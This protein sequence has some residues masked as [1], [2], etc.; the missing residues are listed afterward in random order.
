GALYN[1]RL[2]TRWV[3]RKMGCILAHVPE[4][5]R[6]SRRNGPSTA[7][8]SD[9]GAQVEVRAGLEPGDRIILNPPIGVRDGMRVQGVQDDST[10][11]ASAPPH[12]H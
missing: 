11:M 1:R 7:G 9:D 2:F 3:N 12:S 10:A 4:N 6:F 8:L 5:A